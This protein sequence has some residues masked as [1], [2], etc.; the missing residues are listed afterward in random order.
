MML[1]LSALQD[2]Y[3]DKLQRDVSLANLT[4]VHAGGNADGYLCADSAEALGQMAQ[5]LWQ[6]QIPF[7]VLGGGSNLLVSD[8]GYRGVVLHNQAKKIAVKPQK[9]GLLVSAESGATLSS[10]ARYAADLDLTGMEWAVPVPGTIGGAVFGNAGAYGADISQSVHSATILQRESGYAEW[11]V[12]D[13]HYGYRSSILKQQ[14][15]PVVILTVSLALQPGDPEAIAAKINQIVEARRKTNPSGYSFG[16]TFK[17]P[18]GD[19]AGRLIE[20]AGLKGFQIGGAI[21]SPVHANFINNTGT[22][23][24]QDY[25]RLIGK[26]KTTVKTMFNVDLQLEIELLGEFDDE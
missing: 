4:T 7:Y 24:A 19:K 25:W 22:A 15:L 12:D 2:K 16:S 11:S 13:F 8:A 18:A 3:G 21:I 10:V 20:A 14:H 1:D 17:N 23:T 26:V 6:A 9:K 5:D